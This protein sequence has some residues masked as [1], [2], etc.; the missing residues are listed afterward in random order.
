MNSI[1]KVKSKQINIYTYTN[2]YIWRSLRANEQKICTTDFTSAV[3]SSADWQCLNVDDGIATDTE[4]FRPF[5]LLKEV[6]V[7][8][9]CQAEKEPKPP[10]TPLSPW[11][12]AALPDSLSWSPLVLD[13]P[14]KDFFDELENA[15]FERFFLW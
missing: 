9:L 3:L 15:F 14:C 11:P 6:L 8:L 2:T 5:D 7:N 4:K 1:Y 10:L 12:M 13:G